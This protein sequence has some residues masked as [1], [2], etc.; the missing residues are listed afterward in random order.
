[1]WRLPLS[2]RTKHFLRLGALCCAEHGANPKPNG[3]ELFCITSHKIH[4]SFFA[5]LS[6]RC[7]FDVLGGVSAVRKEN[8]SKKLCKKAQR[9][10]PKDWRISC[11][12]CVGENVRAMQPSSLLCP[13]PLL[14]LALG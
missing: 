11:R 12:A 8:E 4:A 1:M 2:P 3:G 14:S 7:S 10:S 9:E 13:P 6:V 5:S